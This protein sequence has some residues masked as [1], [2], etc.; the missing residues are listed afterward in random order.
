MAIQSI[1]GAAPAAQTA[2]PKADGQI[3]R[4]DFMKLLIAQLQNQD[5]LSPLD[6][7]EF[8]VQLA[9]F[10]SLEQLVGLNEKLD[11]LAA[12]QGLVSQFSS[13]ALIGKQVAGRG[14]EVNLGAGG[15]ASLHYDL[16]ANAAKVTVKVFNSSGALVRQIDAGSQQ[17]GPQSANWDGK[18]SLGQ[19]LPAGVY[20]FEVD[21]LD[22]ASKS[23]PV[24]KQVR[25]VVTGVNLEG[26]EPI[27]E[28]GQLRVPLSSVTTV[29]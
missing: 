22:G 14:N 29:Y 6:N 12:Q 8:A 15:N 28:I 4:D 21:A 24:T 3:T 1:N 9:Q 27:L 20:S 10:N 26:S 5:P 19:S 23:L 7:Q 17:A 25:G 18:N 2:Q 16:G 13:T 11:N